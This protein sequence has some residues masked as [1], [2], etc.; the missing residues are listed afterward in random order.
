MFKLNEAVSNLKKGFR[1]LIEARPPTQDEIKKAYEIFGLKPGDDLS[2]LDK[3]WKELARKNH[4]DLG[5]DPEK[6]KEINWAKDILNDYGYGFRG[7]SSAGRVDWEAIK[8]R[9][10]KNGE[11]NQAIAKKIAK[12]L[13]THTSDYDK[14]FK[15]YIPDLEPQPMVFS[16]SDLEKQGVYGSSAKWSWQNKDKS[17]VITLEFNAQQQNQAKSLGGGGEDEFAVWVQTDL[18]RNGKKYKIGRR[19]YQGTKLS[20]SLFEPSEIFP[21]KGMKK[22]GGESR[23][24]SK[25]QRR[26]FESALFHEL[27]GKKPG[28]R[29]WY[30]PID[31]TKALVIAR[32]VVMRMGTWRILGIWQKNDSGYYT[33]YVPGDFGHK[34][35]YENEKTLKLIKDIM[36]LLKDEKQNAAENLAKSYDYEKM[37]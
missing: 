15:Q 37:T 32:A 22:I 2:G 21:A 12:M 13:E 19:D 30:L 29:D 36:K 28:E 31:D 26:D 35:M 1:R 17:T 23:A 20:T 24:G 34:T 11:I 25:M 10:E 16:K 14:Y 18:Y 6:M 33:K 3:L 9:N 27:G 7:G 8:Q 4:P 5:G